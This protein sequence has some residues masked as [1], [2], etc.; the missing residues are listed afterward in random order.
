MFHYSVGESSCVY[1][2][3]IYIQLILFLRGNVTHMVIK[4]LLT[5]CLFITKCQYCFSIY[6]KNVHSVGLYTNVSAWP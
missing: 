5:L 3:N 6:S 2:I 4:L 1:W